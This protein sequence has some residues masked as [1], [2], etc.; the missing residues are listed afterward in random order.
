MGKIRMKTIGEEDV[1]KK[2]Q[3]DAEKRRE[4]KKQKKVEL[5]EVNEPTV[6]E[7]VQA[8]EGEDKKQKKNKKKEVA[9]A[10]K[11]RRHLGK[12]YI[13]AKKL[14]DA[15][16][17]YE[18]DEALAL[19]KKA[20][21]AS[22]DESIEVHMNLVDANVKGEVAFPHG[23][24]KQVRVVIA[25]DELLSKL[26][27]GIMEFD[28]LIA[29]PSFM[30]KLVKYARVLGPKG[31]MPNPKNGTVVEDAKKAMDKFQSGSVRF[32]SE[33]KFPLLHLIVGKK[34]FA[35][36]DL[37]ENVEVLLRAVQKKNIVDMFMTSTMGPSLQI[38][39]EKI[40]S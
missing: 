4:A 19:I 22:F 11:N 30:P 14:V 1:E 32:K 12:K 29:H 16:K 38:D 27:D 35:D 39:F 37:K 10:G 2:Q 9:K 6:A 8:E 20:G 24:G 3:Q 7:E 40:T 36:K 15:E 25:D 23:T 5:G 18:L 17:K 28:I 33:A 13:S 34:S 31:L 26:D 21:Y